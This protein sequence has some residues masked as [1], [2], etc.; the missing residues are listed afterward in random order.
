MGQTKQEFIARMQRDIDDDTEVGCFAITGKCEKG[1]VML[2]GIG[3]NPMDIVAYVTRVV[4]A[5]SQRLDQ[6]PCVLDGGIAMMLRLGG[7]ENKIEVDV[8]AVETAAG[9]REDEDDDDE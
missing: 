8:S 5:A 9:K 1:T 2:T 3:G 4:K 6:E 7:Q